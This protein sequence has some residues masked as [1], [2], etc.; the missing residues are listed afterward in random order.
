MP[1]ETNAPD[2]VAE[3]VKVLPPH[4]L[5]SFEKAHASIV[6]RYGMSPGLPVLVRM[7]LGCATPERIRREFE[8]AV[9]EITRKTLNPPEDGIFDEDC[10]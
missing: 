10:L 4:L 5:E 3:L 2:E 6:E 9:L 1:T 7:W 8:S